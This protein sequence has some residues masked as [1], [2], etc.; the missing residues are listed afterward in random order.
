MFHSDTRKVREGYREGMV[1]QMTQEITEP[2]I[3]SENA[4]YFTG[5]ASHDA[6]LIYA[7]A[8]RLCELFVVI[9]IAPPVLVTIALAAL[10][11]LWTMGRPVLV[12]QERVGKGGRIFKQLKLRTRV[13]GSASEHPRMT[14]L[15]RFLEDS[16]LAELPQLWNVLV[17]DISIVGPRPESPRKADFYREKV[18]NYELRQSVRPGITGYAQV[19]L[20][21]ASASTTIEYDLHYVRHMD[22]ALD[23]MIVWHS[24]FPGAERHRQV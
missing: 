16:C 19:Y 12:K 14:L 2:K 24:L 22:A 6:N 5:A 1:L 23:L 9:A 8:K 10:A 17:G 4:E 13:E 20:G 15:G 7:K 21:S 11:I 18:P 3:P